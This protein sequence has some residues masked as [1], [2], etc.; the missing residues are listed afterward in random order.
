MEVFRVS[1]KMRIVWRFDVAMTVLATVSRILAAWIL[2]RAIFEGKDFVNGFTFEAMLSYYIVC[3]ILS[4]VDFS[5]NIS[6]EVSNLILDGKFSGHMVTPMNPMLFFSMMSGGESAFHLG[7]SL[8]A[9]ALCA[10]AFGVDIVLAADIAAILLAAAMMAAGLAFMAFYQ[11]FI[12][13]LAFKFLDINFIK[14]TLWSMH[15]FITGAL[16]PL[17]LLPAPVFSALRL[18]PFAHVVYTPAMLL[19]GQIDAG[20]GLIGFAVLAAW[21]AAMAGVAQSAYRRLRIKYDG[22]GI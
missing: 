9:A 20:E 5:N 8:A 16:I 1:F 12:G 22:V 6:N 11:Y 14:H 10:F 19:T 13:I 7:F 2:W 18:L 15:G 17:S 3:S 21:T 4:S